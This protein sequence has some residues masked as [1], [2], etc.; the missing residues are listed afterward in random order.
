MQS[1]GSLATLGNLLVQWAVVISRIEIRVNSYGRRKKY[2][3]VAY[4]GGI[5]LHRM[6]ATLAKFRVENFCKVIRG[7]VWGMYPNCKLLR[8][9]I[10]VL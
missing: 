3:V 9:S 7:F 4:F 8:R 6:G 10:E 1:R 2:R 5:S